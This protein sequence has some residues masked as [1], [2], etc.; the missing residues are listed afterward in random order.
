V[1]K[2]DIVTVKR[3]HP[4]D[5]PRQRVAKRARTAQDLRAPGTRH[6][7]RDTLPL[8]DAV[9]AAQASKRRA[10]DANR[11]YGVGATPP[12]PAKGDGTTTG[13][14]IWA[15]RWGTTPIVLVSVIPT[16]WAVAEVR[17]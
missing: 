15:P 4:L 8:G 3:A 6:Q 9:C 13:G 17:S 12:V 2:T 11:S 14:A 1:L 5:R 7:R 16:A 10:D